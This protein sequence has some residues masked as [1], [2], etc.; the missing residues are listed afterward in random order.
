LVLQDAQGFTPLMRLVAAG[1]A[2]AALRLLQQGDCRLA[3]TSSP[4]AGGVTVL[5]L[6]CS[7]KVPDVELVAALVAAGG[8]INHCVQILNGFLLQG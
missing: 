6:A 7:R 1:E 5:H 4:A 2:A 8:S 3:A